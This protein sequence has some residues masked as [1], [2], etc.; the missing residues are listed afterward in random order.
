VGVL[1]NGPTDHLGKSSRYQL[2]V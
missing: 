1:H 2:I